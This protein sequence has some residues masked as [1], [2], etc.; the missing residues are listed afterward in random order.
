[1]TVTF[2]CIPVDGGRAP[3]SGAPTTCAELDGYQTSVPFF[4]PYLNADDDQVDSFVV[5]PKLDDPSSISG[6]VTI[7]GAPSDVEGWYSV[8]TDL[9]QSADAI[10]SPDPLHFEVQSGGEMGPYYAAL[11]VQAHVSSASNLEV[12]F[13]CTPD[14]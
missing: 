5:I 6:T 2:R 11:R 7:D 14:R 1:M 9:D 10:D 12:E 13:S 8:Q 4:A 3:T